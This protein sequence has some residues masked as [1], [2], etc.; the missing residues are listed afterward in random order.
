MRVN[1]L[2][3]EGFR[4]Y[5]RSTVNFDPGINVITGENAQG[6][7]NLLEAV[8]MLTC[9]KSFRTRFDKELIEF[10]S[11]FAKIT[12][13]IYAQNRPQTIEI[14]LQQGRKK[15]LRANGSKTNGAELTEVLSSVLF[16]PDDL[17][18]IREGPSSRRKLMDMAISQLRPGYQKLISDYSRLLEQKTR[19]LRDW[20]E[21]KSLLEFLDD[22]SAQMCLYSSRI[23]RYRSSFVKRLDE[24][25]GSI[26]NKLSSGKDTMLM[27][28][29]T[30]STVTDPFASTENIYEEILSHQRSHREAELSSGNCLTGIHKDDI[31]IFI[32]GRSAKTYASQGQTRTAALSIKLAEREIHLAD[33]GEYPI[34]L[35]DDV[36]SELDSNRQD[37]VLSR[38]SGGQTLITCCEDERIVQ[39]TG[40][41]VIFI[42]NGKVEV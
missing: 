5:S 6:K 26:H 30:V 18:I 34:L 20:H 27:N 9:G 36:L 28:Y 40:G 31:D 24:A 35:L 29:R 39:R 42:K 38:I 15:I 8:Y 16:C 10:S 41:K 4:N 13:D 19:I 2:T 25:A 14:T 22:I 12:A 1:T 37:F 23:I 7:T 21:K 11:P 33:S 3:L 32:N 17:Y